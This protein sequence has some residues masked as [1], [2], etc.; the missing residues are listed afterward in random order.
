M[1]DGLPREQ[2]YWRLFEKNIGYNTLKSSSVSLYERC[3]IH[4]VQLRAFGHV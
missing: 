2:V 3:F 4:L 1:F